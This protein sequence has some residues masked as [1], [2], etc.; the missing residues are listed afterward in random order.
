MMTDQELRD[1]VVRYYDRAFNH[2]EFDVV[3]EIASDDQPFVCNSNGGWAVEGVEGIKA[4]ISRQRH[5]FRDFHFTIDYLFVE[6]QKVT[7]WWT[8]TGI[9][10]NRLQEFEPTGERLTYSGASLLLFEN[11]KMVGGRA[12]MD[13]QDKLRALST[14]ATAS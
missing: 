3:N 5:T 8:A 2:G 1:L 10:E 12:A 6:D 7:L 13:L 14:A 4:S 11:D 9:F